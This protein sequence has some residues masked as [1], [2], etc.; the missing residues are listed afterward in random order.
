MSKHEQLQ[1]QFPRTGLYVCGGCGKGEVRV[2]AMMGQVLF[3]SFDSFGFYVCVYVVLYCSTT[4]QKDIYIHTYR[5]ICTCP[6]MYVYVYPYNKFSPSS[7]LLD[8]SGTFIHL[9][10]ACL[11]DSG[12]FTTYFTSRT[13]DT[14]F[15]MHHTSFDLPTLYLV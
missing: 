6:C 7:S 5:S 1:H 13:S 14:H 11:F 4:D 8:S 3:S 2:M 9:C 10:F 15:S 12:T